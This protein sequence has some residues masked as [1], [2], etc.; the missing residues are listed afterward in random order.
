MAYDPD[1]AT[2]S[3]VFV[4]GVRLPAGEV[5]IHIRKDGDL[6]VTRYAEAKFASPRTE[7]GELEHYTDYFGLFPGNDRLVSD[8]RQSFDVARIEVLDTHADEQTDDDDKDDAY[9]TVFQGIVTGVGNTDGPEKMWMLRAQGPG[10]L[11]SKIPASKSFSNGSTKDVLRYI[12]ERTEEKLPFDISVDGTEE[13]FY[14]DDNQGINLV[15]G[16]AET[17]PF[18]SDYDLPGG[19]KTF[20]S[21]KHTVADVVNWLR[22]RTGLRIWFEPTPNG[23]VLVGTDRPTETKHKAHYLDDGELYILDNNALV[24]IS[25]VNTLVVKSKVTQSLGIDD[26]FEIK[27]IKT[28]N[29]YNVAKVRHDPLYEQAGERELIARPTVRSDADTKGGLVN[30][31]VSMLKDEIDEAT[32]GDMKTLLTAPIKPYDTIE[33]KPSCSKDLPADMDTATYEVSRVRHMIRPSGHS[34]TKLN[35]GLH[36]ALDE[37]GTFG[38]FTEE[39]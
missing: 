39:V 12:H 26:V 28:G 3:R 33:A 21:N 14:F 30:E 8:I 19:S 31:A 37:I 32:G 5:D 27:E 34:I 16:F 18:I 23:A 1:C 17:L 29:K 13:S 24:E 15:E 35:V 36:V 4:N 7:D 6:D 22:D 38:V 11:M 25:P 9:S 20:K 10:M 2:D